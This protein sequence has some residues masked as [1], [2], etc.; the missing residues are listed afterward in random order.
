MMGAVGQVDRPVRRERPKTLPPSV[1][2]DS[3]FLKVRRIER[4][5]ALLDQL[6]FVREIH[7]ED[8][9][10]PEG[11][12]PEIYYRYGAAGLACIQWALQSAEFVGQPRTILDLPSGYGR[13]LRMTRAAYPSAEITA[14]DLN[15]DAV[16]FCAKMWDA[17][18]VISRAQ[19]EQIELPGRYDLI[20][21][22]SLLTHLRAERWSEFL[23]LWTDHLEPDGVLVF[24]TQGQVAAGELRTGVRSFGLSSPQRLTC[25]YDHEG[26]GYQDYPGQQGYGLA[27]ARPHW[28]C[29]RVQEHPMLS[30]VG[31]RERGWWGRQDVVA[32]RRLITDPQADVAVRTGRASAEGSASPLGGRPAR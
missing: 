27:V 24:T 23:R 7:P 11:E 5:D 21:V 18:P 31:Y 30:L 13:V 32:C 26:F 25:A 22:G 29:S 20:W 15:A 9:M 6:E 28:V 17:R 2:Q 12:G 8:E 4:W 16:D 14:C 3:L 1:P 10:R 19:P